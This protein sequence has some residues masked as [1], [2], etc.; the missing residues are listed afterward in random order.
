MTL[1]EMMKST[2]YIFKLNYERGAVDGSYVD[3]SISV[4]DEKG[5]YIA[6]VQIWHDRVMNTLRLTYGAF[7]ML[8]DEENAGELLNRI[9]GRASKIDLI[10]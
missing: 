1:T 4:R 2:K 6:T 8:Y 7:H 9:L 10:N 3:Y 5:N